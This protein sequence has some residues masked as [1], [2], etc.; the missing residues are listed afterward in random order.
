M[1]KQTGQRLGCGSS[2]QFSSRGLNLPSASHQTP[3]APGFCALCCGGIWGL[4]SPGLE[5]GILGGLTV[6]LPQHPL[7]WYQESQATDLLGIPIGCGR[8][9]G[10]NF[11][12]Q[13]S[14]AR[15]DIYLKAHWVSLHIIDACWCSSF[16]SL[17]PPLSIPLSHLLS[18]SLFP[19][20]SPSP[21]LSLIS[22]FLSPFSPPLFSL[23]FSISF[24]LSLSLYLPSSSSLFPPLPSPSHHFH[25][26][27]F[28][29]VS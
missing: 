28:V 27:I 5:A 2:P 17:P 1:N 29:S 24:L 21:Y 3:F 10:S 7:F 8:Y 9:Q 25:S 26:L 23:S 4:H 13:E 15:K 12:P 22:L 16:S 14:G 19:L 18:I 11:W 20:S 6:Q